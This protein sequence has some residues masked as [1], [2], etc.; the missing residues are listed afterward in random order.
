MYDQVGRIRERLEGLKQ[1]LASINPAHPWNRQR[2]ADRERGVAALEAQL[3]R[4]E[5]LHTAWVESRAEL[6]ARC[7]QFAHMPRG[8]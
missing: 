8:H 3:D 1:E 5:R 2:I 6:V 4:V 7:G